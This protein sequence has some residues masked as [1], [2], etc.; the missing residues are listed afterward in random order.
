[1]VL[2]QK[3]N[4]SAHLSWAPCADLPAGAAGHSHRPEGAGGGGGGGG[5]GG[6]MV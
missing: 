3:K 4:Q 5:G 6:L 1:M 2:K